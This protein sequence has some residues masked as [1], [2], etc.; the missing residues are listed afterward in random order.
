MHAYEKVRAEM[1]RRITSQVWPQGMTLPHEEVLADEFGVARGT[2]RR[3]MADLTERGLIERKRKAGTKVAARRAHS[4]TLNIPIVRVEITDS[5]A[6]YS[7]KLLSR[8]LGGPELDATGRFG[9]S[10]LLHVRSIHLAD[11]RP[12]QLED[13]L[14]SLD[15]VPQ[16]DAQD[17]NEI[18]PNEWLVEKVPYSAV[19][20][21]LRAESA[22]EMQAKHLKLGH[23]DPVFVIERQTQLD[24]LPVTLVKM[25]HPAAS[26]SIAT[27]TSQFR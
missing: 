17:F 3:A 15:A 9:R 8:V 25:T 20:T 5:G 11:G 19:R 10:K 22:D 4:S 6:Q 13:R 7:Y 26:F 1:L 2:M 16:A 27:Q 23:G 12:Y 14:I 18:S 21:I 24:D